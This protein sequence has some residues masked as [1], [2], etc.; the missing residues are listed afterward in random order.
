MS[1][2]VKLKMYISSKPSQFHFSDYTHTLANMQDKLCTSIVATFLV[3]TEKDQK[4][5]KC[6]SRVNRLNKIGICHKTNI[7]RMHLIKNR[8]YDILV[9][10]L[11]AMMQQSQNSS[12]L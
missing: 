10:P 3:V 7:I 1:L 8:H 5:P 9:Q 2:F 12:I 4:Q 11:K 6:P